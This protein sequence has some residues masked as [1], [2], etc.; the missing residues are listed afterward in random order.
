MGG[1]SQ[2]KGDHVFQPHQ[3]THN[4][5]TVCPR[6]GTRGYKAVA[7]RLHRPVEGCACAVRRRLWFVPCH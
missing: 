3:A 2:A 1:P 5:R 4:D 6:T 7:V